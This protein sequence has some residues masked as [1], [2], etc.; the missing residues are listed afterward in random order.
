MMKS[1]LITLASVFTFSFASCQNKGSIE[2]EKMVAKIAELYNKEAYKEMYTML[3]PEFKAQITE[4][5]LTSFYKNNIN[6][7][8]G[9]IASWKFTEA[10]GG[11]MNYR[12]EFDKGPLDLFLK[13]NSKNEIDG[14][15]WLPA[16]NNDDPEKRDVSKIR[17]NN[18]K[19]TKLEL[20]ADSAALDYLQNAANCGLSIGII[21]GDKTEMLFYGSTKKDNNLLPDMGT[22]YEIGSITKTFTG[23]IL[24]HAINEGKIK[25][26][27]DIRKYL[28]AGYVN[29]EYKGIPITIKNLTNHTSGLPRMP[30]DLEQQP[31]YNPLDPYKNYS[32]EMMLNLLKRVKIEALPAKNEYSNLGV[33]VLGIILAEVYHKPYEELVSTYVTTPLKMS[34][35]K[36]TMPATEKTK[37]ATPYAQDGTEITYWNL[38][39]FAPAGGIKSDM[40]DMLKYL[41]ANMNEINADFRL[42]HEQTYKDETIAV[43]LNWMITTTKDNKT[44]IWHNGGTGG[45]RSFCG[46]IKEK[47]AGVVILSNSG[48]DVDNIARSILREMNK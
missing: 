26:D 4:D 46:Y 41:T 30:D 38:D 34:N 12:V 39:A 45:F 15:Q 9:K 3:S 10:K 36:I 19:Q 22:E 29:L 37:L 17:S 14:I 1:I 6:A 40:E 44:L 2:G 16:K 8:L 25:L 43:G 33:A 7:P 47:K 35:T 23:T 32:K 18:P 13:I 24:A 27:D 48:V 21:N 11:T 42:A 5:Q 28:P 31:D 20:L